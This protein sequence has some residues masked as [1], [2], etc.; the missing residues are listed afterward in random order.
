MG[1]DRVSMNNG[2]T[3]ARAATASLAIGLTITLTSCAAGSPMPTPT[4]SATAK[5]LQTPATTPTPTGSSTPSQ[6]PSSAPAP[7]VLTSTPMDRTCDDVFGLQKLYDYD[8]NMALVAGRTPRLSPTA[9]EQAHLGAITCVLV[10][11]SSS[12]ETEI[13]IAKLTDS[14]TAAKSAELSAGANYQVNTSVRGFFN[15]GMGQFTKGSYW[16]SVSSPSFV[17]PVDASQISFLAASGL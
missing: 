4:P 16:V 5:G 11:L 9:T 12:V 17:N 3:I 2:L 10:N 8:P 15:S 6:S 13:V 14:S 1:F 7:V